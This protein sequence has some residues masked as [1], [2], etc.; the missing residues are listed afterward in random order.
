MRQLPKTTLPLLLE[1]LEDRFLLAVLGPVGPSSTAGGTSNPVMASDSS[2]SSNQSSTATNQ[3]SN[4]TTADNGETYPSGTDSDGPSNSVPPLIVGPTALA[5]GQQAN[6]SSSSSSQANSSGQNGQQ[7]SSS[8]TSYSENNYWNNYDWNSGSA[9]YNTTPDGMTTNHAQSPFSTQ[10]LQ[11]AAN[12]VLVLEKEQENNGHL[13]LPGTLIQVAPTQPAMVNPDRAL[14]AVPVASATDRPPETRG[15]VPPSDAADENQAWSGFPER[16]AEPADGLDAPLLADSGE[17]AP[18]P[19][20]PPQL[21]A[22]LGNVLSRMLPVDWPA[23]A[24]G[25]DQFFAQLETLGQDLR[26]SPLLLRLAP[27]LVVTAIT[28]LTVEM[29]RWCLKKQAQRESEQPGQD[30]PRWAFFPNLLIPSPP[31]ES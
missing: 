12:V 27:W 31:V 18:P 15:F 21:P 16:N 2:P 17:L 22:V 23:L 10:T 7:Q 19:S 26:S 9:K 8:S 25:A 1:A 6:N 24:D 4:P 11:G 30:D 13:P 20:E 28:P 29:L 14:L 3:S 5:S